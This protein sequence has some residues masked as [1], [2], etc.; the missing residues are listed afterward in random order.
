MHTVIHY[1]TVR[2]CWWR[3]ETRLLLYLYHNSKAVFQTFLLGYILSPRNEKPKL[4]IKRPF[5]FFF[6]NRKI[7][8]CSKHD[9]RRYWKKKKSQT[10]SW[11]A[12]SISSVCV[13]S[14]FC[15]CFVSY[16]YV[17]FRDTIFLKVDDFG[18]IG[19][20][21]SRSLKDIVKWESRRLSISN[22][23]NTD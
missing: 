5:P 3:I 1:G 11:A 13:F 14:A 21:S 9:N 15:G 12:S 22:Q 19:S 4:S 20:A 7:K 23:S 2:N 6:L 16:H 8:E 18:R 17:G 10:K